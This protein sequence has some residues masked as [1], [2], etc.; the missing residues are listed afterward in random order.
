MRDLKF[1]QDKYAE[2]ARKHWDLMITVR[3]FESSYNSWIR[4]FKLKK[5]Y[6]HALNRD[7]TGFKVERRRKKWLKRRL[8]NLTKAG[9]ARR[10]AKRLQETK[11]DFYKK[12]IEELGGKVPS[13]WEI[14]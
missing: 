2:V 10:E 14:A 7:Y 4:P 6:G 5:Q 13:T 8:I 12:K 3:S 11:L 1:W 9:A